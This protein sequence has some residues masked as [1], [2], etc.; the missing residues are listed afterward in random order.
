MNDENIL[1]LGD[2]S[3]AEQPVDPPMPASDNILTGDGS[4]LG[5]R[6]N[7]LAENFLEQHK[8]EFQDFERHECEKM[9]CAERFRSWET[10]IANRRQWL[11][12]LQQEIAA[13]R[14]VDIAA[15]IL[16]NMERTGRPLLEIAQNPLFSAAT[17]I[18]KHGKELLQL[19]E[20][21]AADLQK[22]FDAFKSEKREILNE[23]GLD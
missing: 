4:W 22:Q 16:K 7:A 15:D 10:E 11:E 17:L 1:I 18:Q 19:A 8:S 20:R 23:L 14:D 21:Q 2:D 3:A 9:A 5:S 13:Y 6:K 12:S